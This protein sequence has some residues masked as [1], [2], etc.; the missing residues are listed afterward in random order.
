MHTGI[1]SFADRIAYNI[2]SNEI[3]DMILEQL[4]RLY[5]IKIIQ[6]HYF[7]LSNNNIKYI[8]NNNYLCNLRSNGNPYYV[9][10]TKYN[11]IP[12]IYYID[13]KIH[14]NYEKPRIILVRGLFNEEL[15]KNTLLDGEMIKTYDKKWIFVIN[16]IIAYK[17]E[18]LKKKNLEERLNIV[19]DLLENDYTEDSCI[20]VCKYKIKTYYKIHKESI[21]KLIEISKKI[22]YSTRGIYLWNY[23]LNYK[24]ILYNFNEDNIKNVVRNTKDDSKFK[25]YDLL[26]NNNKNKENINKENEKKLKDD[27]KIEEE[28]KEDEKILF[29][30]KST[31]PDV[32]YLY[33]KENILIEKSIGIAN[34]SKLETSKMLREIFK[35]M[36]TTTLVKFKCKYNK[37]FEKWLPLHT[38]K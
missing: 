28:L 6:K 38:I 21:K 3:K 10:F 27:E 25:T 31:E 15:Y 26:Q 4:Y 32:Y 34:V 12:I 37:V 29:I 24:P 7:T 19:Y 18:F 30:S 11:D 35:N 17:G 5:N 22:N 2:K 33:L 14:P 1:I 13:K 23:N 20:D 16:D 36:N 9:Y 8:D